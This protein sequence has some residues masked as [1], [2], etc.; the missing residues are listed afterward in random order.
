VR[1]CN[2]WPKGSP[3]GRAAFG[4][5]RAMGRLRSILDDLFCK[6][7]PAE[8]ETTAYYPA[9]SPAA[10]VDPPG[11]DGCGAASPQSNEELPHGH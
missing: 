9:R 4:P 10:V 5:D 1:V 2:A 6:Q 7:H 3:V 11:T 8:F